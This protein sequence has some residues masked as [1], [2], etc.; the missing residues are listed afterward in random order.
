MYFG[1]PCKVL[2]SWVFDDND[3][4]DYNDFFNDDNDYNDNESEHKK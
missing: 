4:N 3:D 1:K 2:I